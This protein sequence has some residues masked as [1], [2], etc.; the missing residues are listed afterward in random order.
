MKRTLTPR[1]TEIVEL[2]AFGLSQKEIGDK[3]EISPNTVDVTVKN[4]KTKLDLQKSTELAAW[5]FIN[6][7]HITLNLSPI[8]RAMIS[9]SFLALMVVS[10]FEGFNPER[11]FRTIRASR[12]QVS[13][14]LR[15]G[16]RSNESDF[17]LLTA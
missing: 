1:E 4:I 6:T 2:V 13:L 7:Y 16:R 11:S 8:K 9:L 17:Y 5:Y 14:T 12:A 15:S 10:L 3:L